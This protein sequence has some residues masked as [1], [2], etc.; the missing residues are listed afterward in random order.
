MEKS[1][2]QASPADTAWPADEIGIA[3]EIVGNQCTSKRLLTVAVAS[4]LVSACGGGDSSSSSGGVATMPSPQPSPAPSPTPTPTPTATPTQGG[5]A[6]LEQAEAARFLLRAQFSASLTEIEEVRREGR[7]AWLSRHMAY[8]NDQMATQFMRQQG[9]DEVNSQRYHSSERIFDTTIW[10][11]MLSGGNTVRKRIAFALSEYFVIS[12][13]SVNILWRSHAAVAYWD[14]LN[15]HAFGNFRELLEAV[16]LSP[17]MG[18]F[19]D[20]LGSRREDPNTGRMPDENFAREIMQLFTIGLNELN[21][22]GSLK[23]FS[24]QPIE[25]YSND[26]VVGLAR[27]FTGYNLDA[28]GLQRVPDPDNPPRTLFPPELVRRPMTSNPMHWERPSSTSEHSSAEKRFL[29]FAI[30]AGTDAPTSLHLAL[31]RLFQHPNVGPFFGRQMIQRLVT[32]NPSPDYVARV[33]Q[34]FNNNGSGVR[35]DLKAVFKAILLDPE[36]YAPIGLNDMRFGKLREPVVRFIQFA[37]SFGMNKSEG[38]WISRDL[39][40]PN[41]LLGQA[42]LRAPSV[43]NFFRPQYVMPSSVAAANAMVGPEFQLINET[44]VLANINLV[45][46][47]VDGTAP[48]LNDL[49]PTYQTELRLAHNAQALLDHLD[50]VLTAGQLR[51]ATRDAILPALHDIPVTELSNEDVKLRR[52]HIAVT[53]IMCSHDYLIQK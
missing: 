39:S 28:T 25:T 24:G 2:E 15:E 43:F 32:S 20:M 42:P 53:L 5:A 29:G 33:A 22:D 11:Q 47:F 46:S 26:D 49:R 41:S 17:A 48:W 38:Q 50:L 23:T 12:A 14:L 34:A 30:P 1:T 40:D 36:A 18:T 7:D 31:D 8:E 4:T 21:L 27:V 10:N 19:L 35:G 45:E 51:P 9:Y 6:W 16:A 44:T 37:R 3:D 52:I 13:D